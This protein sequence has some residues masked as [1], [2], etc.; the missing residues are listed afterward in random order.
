MLPASLARSSFLAR[1][2]RAALPEAVF[3][4]ARHVLHVPRAGSN[5]TRPRTQDKIAGEVAGG[6]IFQLPHSWRALGTKPILQ[7]L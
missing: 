7:L 6:G 5:I 3:E 1:R 4:T 2:L